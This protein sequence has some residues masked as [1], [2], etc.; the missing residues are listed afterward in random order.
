MDDEDEYEARKSL[1]KMR[2]RPYSISD[3]FKAS[4]DF[5]K[6]ASIAK[7]LQYYSKKSSRK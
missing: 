5:A 6:E 3:K 7:V 1:M 2:R 4:K